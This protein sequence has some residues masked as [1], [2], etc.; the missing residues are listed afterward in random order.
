MKKQLK[1]KLHKTLNNIWLQFSLLLSCP[2]P[3]FFFLSSSF[4]SSHLL[5]FSLLTSELLSGPMGD[6]AHN[7]TIAVHLHRQKYPMQPFCSH[8]LTQ[9]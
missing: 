2:P 7:T 1:E 6:S 8:T 9:I 4:M 5:S 3:I